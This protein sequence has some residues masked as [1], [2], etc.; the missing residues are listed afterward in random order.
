MAKRKPMSFGTPKGETG[1]LEKLAERPDVVAKAVAEI[2]AP[3]NDKP[4]TKKK[5]KRDRSKLKSMNIWVSEQGRYVVKSHA[6]N[7]STGPGK[8]TV[9]SFAIRAFNKLLLEEGCEIQL[10]FEDE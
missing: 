5:P 4:D 7:P 10:A 9:E 3:A 2:T 8:E 6:N 1:A